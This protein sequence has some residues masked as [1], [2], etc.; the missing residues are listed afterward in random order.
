MQPNELE[1]SKFNLSLK[2]WYWVELKLSTLG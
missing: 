2:K 1:Q